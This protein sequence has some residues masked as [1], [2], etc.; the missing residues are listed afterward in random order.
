[1]SSTDL[2]QLT[3]KVDEAVVQISYRWQIFCQLFDSGQENINT[4]NQRGSVVFQMFQKLVIDDVTLSLARLT[5]P[6]TSA[7]SE[8]ASLMNL[9]DQSRL[10][11]EATV[12]DE[13]HDLVSKLS[14]D[15]RTIRLHR[16]KALAHA[17]LKCVLGKK[18]LPPLTYAELEN[19]MESTREIMRQLTSKL[20]GWSTVY[21]VLIPYGC[22]GSTLLHVLKLGNAARDN[23]A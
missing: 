5:D 3:S 8:N 11:L 23:G 9:L 14:E 15:V 1:M 22:D 16:N 13:L 20:F 21:D 18:D 12:Y 2:E 17:D 6:P 4:L 19:A 7:G 10:R